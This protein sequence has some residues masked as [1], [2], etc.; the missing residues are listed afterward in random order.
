MQNQ[1]NTKNALQK[2]QE[3]LAKIDAQAAE[4]QKQA[5]EEAEKQKKEKEEKV[6]KD[7]KAMRQDLGSH[8]DLSGIDE[9]IAQLPKEGL[10]N[11]FMDGINHGLNYVKGTVASKEH[12]NEGKDIVSE[13]EDNLPRTS[14]MDLPLNTSVINIEDFATIGTD[15]E[16]AKAIEDNKNKSDV[17]TN[18]FK[19][20]LGQITGTANTGLKIAGNSLKIASNSLGMI[21]GLFG[22]AKDVSKEVLKPEQA[23]N[24]PVSD[25]P[26]KSQ[27]S[28]LSESDIGQSQQARPQISP[29]NETEHNLR[30][31]SPQNNKN[32]PAK[33]KNNSSQSPTR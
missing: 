1:S 17:K 7:A 20:A 11:R 18:L 32:D 15:E 5:E 30:N 19:E 23:R 10:V 26:S 3:D 14:I 24:V 13:D 29:N 27:I 2:L 6:K 25:D 28:G 8:V 33:T 16:I 12:N 9:D 21:T 31:K 4:R 22:V